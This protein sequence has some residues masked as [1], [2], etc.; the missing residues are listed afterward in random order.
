MR[1]LK[2]RRKLTGSMQQFDILIGEWTTVES[3]LN[4]PHRYTDT[5]FEWPAREWAALVWHFIW[6]GGDV[7]SA[8]S[9]I[10]R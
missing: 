4:F 2:S 6:E 1:L 8:Y 3:I 5:F 9:V 7:P 10:G